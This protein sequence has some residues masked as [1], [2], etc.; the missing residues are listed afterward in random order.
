MKHN[1]QAR[2][3]PLHSED[4]ETQTVGCRHTN[5]DICAKNQMPDVCAFAR[6]DRMC[7]APP[8]SWPQQFRI[9]KEKRDH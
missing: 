4:S 7:F 9:L 6:S 8:K 1:A 5:P 2:N 3:A